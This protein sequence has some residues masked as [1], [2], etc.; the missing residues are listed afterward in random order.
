M[1]NATGGGTAGGGGVAN[2]MLIL[3]HGSVAKDRL[4]HFDIP[5]RNASKGA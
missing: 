4:P 2:C 3:K 1:G 5:C